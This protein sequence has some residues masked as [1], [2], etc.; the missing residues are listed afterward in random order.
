MQKQLSMVYLRSSLPYLIAIAT[1]LAMA[2]DVWPQ[3][4]IAKT[5]N[6]RITYLDTNG[7]EMRSDVKQTRAACIASIALLYPHQPF[8]YYCTADRDG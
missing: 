8:D 1:V 2:S 3:D 5:R 6:W 7:K 4:K